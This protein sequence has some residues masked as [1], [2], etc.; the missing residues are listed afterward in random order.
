MKAYGGDPKK[1]SNWLMI[2]VLRMINED[3]LVPVEMRLTPQYLAELLKLVTPALSISRPARACW[4]KCRRAA[5]HRFN[6]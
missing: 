2:D 4:H 5:R 3:N 1:V 6:W